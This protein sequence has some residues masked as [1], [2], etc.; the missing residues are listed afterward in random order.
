[1]EAVAL[2][3]EVSTGADRTVRPWGPVT[4]EPLRT[5]PAGGPILWPAAV[6]PDG[7]IWSLVFSPDGRLLPAAGNDGAVRARGVG[8]AAPAPRTVPPGLRD[9][10]AALAEDGRYD[11]E[12]D[13]AG[14]F[15]YVIGPCRFEPGELD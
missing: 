4:G 14:R 3:D 15:W 2:G 9:G 1:M 7:R 10:W 13:A 11:V 5:L 12:G 8:G 6:T